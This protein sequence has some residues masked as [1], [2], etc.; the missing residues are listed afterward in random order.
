MYYNLPDNRT[1][2]LN[3]VTDVSPIQE[4]GRD[5]MS[6]DKYRIG[7]SLLINDKQI[8]EVTELYHFCDWAQAKK[9]IQR[10]RADLIEI[11]QLKS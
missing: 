4:Y 5:P 3:C 10:I 11:K 9:K 6:I 2:D 7:F 1:I 8:V